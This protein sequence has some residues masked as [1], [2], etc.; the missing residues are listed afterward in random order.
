MIMNSLQALDNGLLVDPHDQQSIAGALLKLVSDKQLWA[1]C[2]QNGLKNIHLFS[3]PAHCKNYLSRIASCKPRQPQWQRS[4]SEPN[5]TDTGSP[6]DSFRDIKDLSL[7]L[8]LTIDGDKNDIL[9]NSLDSDENPV[10]DKKRLENSIST[11]CKSGI[12]V[13]R[14]TDQNTAADDLPAFRRRKFIFVIAMDCDTT[15]DVLKITKAVMEAAKNEKSKG[16]VGFI[17]STS[18]T[19]AEVNSL[20]LSEGLTPSDFDAYICNSGSELY[21]PSS[22]TEDA[23]QLP[24]VLDLDYHSHIEYRWGGEALRKTLVRWAASICDKNSAAGNIAEDETRSTPYCYA[25]KIS[26]PTLVITFPFCA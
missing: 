19:I 4:D 5:N 16:T 17:L 14:S 8:K 23:S 22:S 26:N 21:H 1:K 6:N 20:I 15:A 25:F 10:N 7:N 11:L 12:G 9:D 24:Y 2:R 13:A 18:L 3:W